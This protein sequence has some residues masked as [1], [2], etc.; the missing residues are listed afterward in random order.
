MTN[1][2]AAKTIVTSMFFCDNGNLIVDGNNTEKFLDAICVALSALLKQ[3][4]PVK[5]ECKCDVKEDFWH[6][7]EADPP[8]EE[9]NYFTLKKGAHFPL[10]CSYKDGKWFYECCLGEIEEDKIIYWTNSKP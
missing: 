1:K 4:E 2:E 10:V 5:N 3:Q 9:G 6:V 8:K 7:A